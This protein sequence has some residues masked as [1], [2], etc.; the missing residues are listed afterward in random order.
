MDGHRVPDPAWFEVTS[1]FPGD[2]ND[3]T[4]HAIDSCRGVRDASLT[5]ESEAIS[6]RIMGTD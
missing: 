2:R 4:A 6:E 1:A 5:E 3:V